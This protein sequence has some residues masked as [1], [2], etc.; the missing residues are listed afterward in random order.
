M[1]P[2]IFKKDIHSDLNKKELSVG[3]ELEK[4]M[5]EKEGGRD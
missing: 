2:G 1:I 4:T 5:S 3:R